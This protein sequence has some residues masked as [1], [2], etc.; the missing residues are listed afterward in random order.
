M[1]RDVRDEYDR[2]A[3]EIRL[4]IPQTF[5]EKLAASRDPVEI[6]KLLKAEF[7]RVLDE[8]E[9]EGTLQ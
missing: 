8:M 5:Y 6:G 4:R 2:L 9:R 3:D 1:K 7:T